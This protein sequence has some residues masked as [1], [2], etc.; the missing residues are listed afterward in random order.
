MARL[1]ALTGVGGRR[2]HVP[3]LMMSPRPF[4]RQLDIAFDLPAKGPV[5]IRVYDVAGREVHR[6]DLGEQPA[7]PVHTRWDGKL[8]RGV[9]ASPG[10]YFVRVRAPG[11]G[12]DGRII[13][14]R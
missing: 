10:V 8:A 11:V 2:S 4:R 6:I 5:V 13:R 1:A 7:G 3:A 12:L 9:D 14:L